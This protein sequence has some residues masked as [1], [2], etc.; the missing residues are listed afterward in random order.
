LN[1]SIK[2]N[3]MKDLFGGETKYVE[4]KPKKLIDALSNYRHS[5]SDKKCKNCSNLI[6]KR[7]N[8]KNYYK[9]ALLG[10]SRSSAT[11]IRLNNVC[12]HYE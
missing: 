2:L 7:Q 6:K 4:P 8:M 1:G 5:E 9:C 11:D 3:D 10:V 12:D